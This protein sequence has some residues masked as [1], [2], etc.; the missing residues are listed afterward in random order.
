VDLPRGGPPT[1]A[2]AGLK[3]AAYW[4]P[5]DDGDQPSGHAAVEEATH[6]A[7]PAAA[8]YQHIYPAAVACLT[9]TLDEL[10]VHLQLQPEHWQAS[11]TPT[12]WSAP[13]ARPDVAPR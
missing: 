10:T 4:Q 7:Q 1:A 5:F 6:R 9:S 13:S 2:Q 12:C 8:R 11:A 3:A